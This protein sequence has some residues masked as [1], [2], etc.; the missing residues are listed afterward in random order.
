MTWIFN[1]SPRSVAADCFA[2][3]VAAGNTAFAAPVATFPIA[4]QGR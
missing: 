4:L 1:W 2:I 3:E